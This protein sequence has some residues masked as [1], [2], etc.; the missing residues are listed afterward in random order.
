MSSEVYEVLGYLHE[1]R[2][3]SGSEEASIGHHKGIADADAHQL[4]GTGLIP[5]GSR[6][7]NIVVAVYRK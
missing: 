4:S 3:T 2:P 5:S 6:A 7:P 1:G